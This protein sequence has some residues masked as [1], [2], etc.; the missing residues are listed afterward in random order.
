MLPSQ[1]VQPSSN[2]PSR[3]PYQERKWLIIVLM[4][5]AFVVEAG[6]GQLFEANRT[7]KALGPQL[8]QVDVCLTEILRLVSHR[9]DENQG[10][11]LEMKHLL[12]HYLASTA[13]MPQIQSRM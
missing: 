6:N 5:A 7:A 8:S 1:E 4:S 12:Q 10:E 3:K 9:G 2:T 13:S 11:A